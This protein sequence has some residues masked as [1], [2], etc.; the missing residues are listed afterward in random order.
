MNRT[1]HLKM[2]QRLP[3]RATHCC[4]TRHHRTRNHGR[5]RGN[6]NGAVTPKSITRPEQISPDTSNQPY[7]HCPLAQYRT[8]TPL[9][10]FL[11][12]LGPPVE[13][14]GGIRGGKTRRSINVKSISA[15]YNRTKETWSESSEGALRCA[16]RRDLRRSDLRGRDVEYRVATP[17]CQTPIGVPEV[18][19][20][21]CERRGSYQFI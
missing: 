12:A 16:L 13:R 20:A 14:G 18:T 7:A 19:C 5:R 10:P 1:I 17:P 8:R 2:T 6:A 11:G 21:P 9:F 15:E 4:M 3:T